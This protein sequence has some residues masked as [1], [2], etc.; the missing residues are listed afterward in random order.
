MIVMTVDQRDSRHRADAVPALLEELAEVPTVRP[1]QRTAGDEVQ[2]VLNDAAAAVGVALSLGAGGSW[3]VGLGVGAVHHP[4]P[5]ET[6]AGSGPAFEA[7]RSAV[8]R[9]KRLSGHL[10]VEIPTDTAEAAR[11]E[12]ELTLLSLTLARRTPHQAKAAS[13]RSAGAT[14]SEIA[15]RLGITQQAVSARLAAGHVEEVGALL[16]AVVPA[17][18]RALAAVTR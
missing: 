14:Q 1:F 9:A 4:L 12:A 15:Q 17:L 2:A 10:A 16:D 11:L 13:L 18:D 7:A 3:S 8:E 6:R 5:E